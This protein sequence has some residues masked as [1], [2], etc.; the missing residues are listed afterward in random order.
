[1]ANA[2]ANVR[3]TYGHLMIGLWL[4]LVVVG[5]VGAFVK[6]AVTGVIGVFGP[7]ILGV[8][9]AVL[10]AL[11]VR[12]LSERGIKWDWWRYPF[13]LLTAFIPLVAALY[14][15]ERRKLVREHAEPE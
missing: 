13:Y 12:H 14:W 4:L 8:G 6:P 10:E 15:Y 1:M 9:C 11:D 2:Q 7:I 5:V 3:S